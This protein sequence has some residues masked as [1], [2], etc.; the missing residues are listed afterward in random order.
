MINILKTRILFC[1]VLS[2]ILLILYL[3]EV[4]ASPIILQVQY[5]SLCFSML[6]ILRI[7]LLAFAF[8][9]QYT[10]VSLLP[11]SGVGLNIEGQIRKDKQVDTR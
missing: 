11:R 7:L 1:K 8:S 6:F 2:D 9:K 3:L 10:Y 5:L 4:I